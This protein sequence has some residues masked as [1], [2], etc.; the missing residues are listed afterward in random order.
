MNTAF[1][2]E[3]GDTLEIKINVLLL[4]QNNESVA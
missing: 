1:L 4:Y 2:A 3:L